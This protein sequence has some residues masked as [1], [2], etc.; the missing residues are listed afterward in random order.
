MRMLELMFNDSIV[1]LIISCIFATVNILIGC[2][3]LTGKVKSIHSK[4]I[5]VLLA[6]FIFALAQILVNALQVFIL[7]LN[8]NS[9]THE[10]TNTYAFIR[11]LDSVTYSCIL[12]TFY[13]FLFSM[14]RVQIQLDKNLCSVKQVLARLNRQMRLE[15]LII[16]GYSLN[17]AI[18][19]S[20]D[21]ILDHKFF[22]PFEE[23]GSGQVSE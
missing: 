1:F 3:T 15:R 5:K 20:L 6:F 16:A 4:T 7:H 18:F 8:I 2:K 10:L 23:D 13:V 17:L 12:I 9:D 19:I 21:I 14:K 11:L 22:K